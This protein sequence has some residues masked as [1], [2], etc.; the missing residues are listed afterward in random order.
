MAFGIVVAFARVGTSVNFIV[1]PKLADSGVP[2]AVWTSTGMTA[3]SFTLGLCAAFIDWRGEGRRKSRNDGIKAAQDAEAGLLEQPESNGALQQEQEEAP[4]PE[5]IKLSDIKK[6]PLAS[7]ILFF[8]CLLMY[9]AIMT[10]YSVASDI[11]QNTGN[12]YSSRT[13]STFLSIPNFMAIPFCPIFGTVQDKYGRALNFIAL[14]FIGLIGGHVVF[15]LMAYD[16]IDIPP[17]VVMVWI[18][19]CYSLGSSMIWPVLARVIDPRM[20]AT[21]YGTMTSVQNCGLALFPL[22][23]G[24]IQD[25][26]GIEGTTEQY[27]IPIFIFIG[28]AVIGFLLTLW[29]LAVDRIRHAGRMNAPASNQT[30]QKELTPEEILN[31]ESDSITAGDATGDLD[32]GLVSAEV[33]IQRLSFSAAFDDEEEEA[34]NLEKAGS[35]SVSY[36]RRKAFGL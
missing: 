9:V 13:A 36:E 27:T 20:L 17:P 14:V 29:L 25:S 23:I 21:G 30:F 5:E 11:L 16:V 12:K 34:L 15:M 2:T 10:F 33:P 31:L 19:L 8:M 18:G 26:D 22:A 3:L 32:V 24:V 28:C 6:F 4:E 1:T 35:L 7:W